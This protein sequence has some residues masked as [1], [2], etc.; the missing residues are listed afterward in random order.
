M[1]L[2]KRFRTAAEKR[3]VS[4]IVTFGSHPQSD[5][6]L[7]DCSL[8]LGGSE[9]RAQVHG[10]LVSYTIPLPGRH[11]VINSLG[12]L[13]GVDAVGADWK[14]A[15]T[16]LA[17]LPTL[18]NRIQQRIV[19]VI[20]GT[21][22]LID[23][24]FSANPASMRAA[25]EVLQLTEPGKNGR[26]VVVLGEMKE[27][28]KDSPQLHA[29]LAESVIDTGVDKVFTLGADMKHLF[30]ALP[31]DKRG[32]HGQSLKDVLK[33]TVD[34]IHSGDILLFKNSNRTK[35]EK[36]EDIIDALNPVN[37]SQM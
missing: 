27:L 37:S 15:A 34:Y 26:R 6:Q 21:I 33:D 10:E 19:N 16:D 7:L 30:D 11:N 4:R 28:G 17:S 20:D 12:I 13:A 1:S 18:T 2:Y 32:A 23:D 36:L 14:Q 3:S 5:V 22:E 9:V 35:S 29:G 8:S 25:F 31:D 24:T